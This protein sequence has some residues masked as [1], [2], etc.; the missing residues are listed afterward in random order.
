MAKQTAKSWQARL[1]AEP[2][3]LTTAFVESLRIDRR[4]AKHDIAGSVAHAEMLA[5]AGLI[6][7]KDARAIVAALHAIAD[8]L[9]A[10]TLRL[11][12][13]HEDI[14][15]AIEAALIARAGD[16]GRRL[17]TARS[18]NDQVATDLRLWLRDAID[19]DAIPGMAALQSALVGLADR[20][21]RLIMPSYTHLQTAQP[22]CLGA[23][24]LAYVEMLQRD[25]DRLL[26]ARKRVNVCPLG[27]G[28]VAGTTLPIDR[29]QTARRLGFADIAANSIDA[30]SDRDFIAEYLA[31]AA[32]CQT[33]LS[34]LAEDWIFFASQECGFL[35]LDDAYCTGSSMMPQKRN[36]DLLELVRGRAGRTHGALVG[37]LTLLKG[38]PTAYNRDLQEDKTHLF[39][40][41]DSL[42]AS[43]EVAAAIVSTASFDESR[44]AA[45]AEAGFSDATALAEYLVGRDVPFR[46]AHQIVGRLVASCEQRGSRLADLSLEELQAACDRVEPDVVKHL[47][48]ANVVKAYRSDGAAGHRQL[49]AQLARWKRRL[50]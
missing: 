17:H 26:D 20:Q 46:T 5:D 44:L 24:L 40:A 9:D 48:A 8:D 28:A 38:L 30:T 22:I 23:Y 18:R 2:A 39:A 1:S 11:D 27:C 21:G 6:S 36:A 4:L 35:R 31:A 7:R 50:A 41:H 32:I 13:A 10:G 49:T 37:I 45:A 34:R 12:P 33:H 3:D 25:R 19:R 29:R 14:H 16:A 42:V 15:M 47:G 43:L